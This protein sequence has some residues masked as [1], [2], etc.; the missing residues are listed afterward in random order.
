MI[1]F[2]KKML[3]K[4]FIKYL[5][6]GGTSF[7]LDYFIFYIM[8]KKLGIAEVYSN[9]TAIFIAFWYNFLLNR[10]WSFKSKEPF[11]KQIIYYLSLMLFNML[12]Y[13]AFIYIIKERVGIDPIIGKIIAMT[14]IV[15]WNFVLYKTVIFKSKR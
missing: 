12:F 13:S 7:L 2:I 6:V 10:I 14:M 15:A 9:V 4:D 11:F 8:Y 5:I 3:N 1:N